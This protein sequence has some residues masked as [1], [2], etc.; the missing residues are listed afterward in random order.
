MSIEEIDS[1]RVFK[2]GGK[3][4]EKNSFEITQHIE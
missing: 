4:N 3:G 2:S 1:S